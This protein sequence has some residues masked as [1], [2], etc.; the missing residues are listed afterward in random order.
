MAKVERF[1]VAESET[2]EARERRRRSTGRSS[3][4]SYIDAIL[5]LAP[6]AVCDLVRPIEGEVPPRALAGYDAVFLSG[7]PMHL[8]EDTPEV[9]RQLDFMREIFT[10]GT[11]SFGS[12]VGLQLAVAAAGG[13]IRESRRGHEAGFAR[14][15]TPTPEG[16][17]H[18]LLSGRPDVYDAPSIHADEVES[19][20]PEGA[21]CLAGNRVTQVQ[22][23]E[24]TFG[25]GTFWGVQYHPELPLSEIADALRR[26]GD[27]LVDQGF[28][29]DEAELEDYATLVDTL[30]REPDRRDVAWR[31]GL[32]EQVIDAVLRRTELSNFID[33]LAR[34][35]MSRRN[36]A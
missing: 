10:S 19:L 5:R 12:C 20:P 6:G 32:D 24:V 29:R 2:V 17:M 9:R 26:Q 30:D 3:G 8:Y 14:R 34:P 4:E 33:H 11:P 28:V 31:L 16:R 13:R 1:L 15:I 21:V 7:S 18:P 22:A 27:D 25:S 35:T 36:R 23:A